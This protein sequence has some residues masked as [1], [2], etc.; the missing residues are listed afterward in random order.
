[1]NIVLNRIDER[2]IHGQVLASWAKRLQV[3]EILVIDDQLAHDPFAETVLTMALPSNINLK[4]FDVA[5]GSAYIQ[6]E[7]DQTPPN[8]ILLVKSPEVIKQLWDYGYHPDSLNIGG[9]SAG[10]SRRHLCRGLYAAD[11]EIS[12]FQELEDN[13]TKVYVQ[14]VYGENKIHFRDLV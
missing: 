4:I 6:K 8:T 12:I 13:G 14:V 1:M 10:P 2:L 5:K 9:M 7:M 11:N 3:R